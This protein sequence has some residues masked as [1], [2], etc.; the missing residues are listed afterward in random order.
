MYIFIVN[1]IAGNGRAKRTFS[2]I[3]E[4]NLYQ[5]I[6]SEYYI[7]E[8]KGHAEVITRKLIDQQADQIT[9]IIVVSGDGT[10][11]E[12][13]NGV[14]HHSIPI[15]FIPGGS[16]ND[17][18]RGCGITGRPLEILHK[19]IY[20]NDE[21]PYWLGNYQ[22]DQLPTRFFTNNIGFGFDAEIARK[23]NASKYK[24]F[25]NGFR[26]GKL[27]YI[28]ALVQV[29]LRFKP[30]NISL[31]IDGQTYTYKDCWMVTVSNHPYYG[32]GMKVI[33]NAKIRPTTFS[34]MIVHS[35]SKWKVLG[36]FMTVLTG[37]HV[38]F[39]EIE[40]KEAQKLAIYSEE[41]IPFQVDGETSTCHSS[42]IT[43]QSK[44]IG[45]QG[46]AAQQLKAK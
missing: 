16:G 1:P 41:K 10:L 38:R 9:A 3:L 24:E 33:P 8:Y 28:I 23:A 32:G 31:E 12:V 5:R 30:I 2:K 15:S 45:V 22:V 26:I 34:V 21:I 43:K 11:H 4:S 44:S 17:F 37:D 36:L 20:E 42:V 35:I 6:D 39:K 27:S 40:I 29:L 46:T 18:A 14:G 13:M 19:I 7:T 25:L